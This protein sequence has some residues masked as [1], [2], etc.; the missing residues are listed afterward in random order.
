MYAISGHYG[1]GKTVLASEAV[2]MILSKLK[3]TSKDVDVHVLTFGGGGSSSDMKYELLMKD[4]KN[5]CFLDQAVNVQHFA[6]FLKKFTE[7]HKNHLT[8]KQLKDLK[9]PQEA[10]YYSGGDHFKGVLITICEMMKKFN[11]TCIIMIDELVLNLACRKTTENGKTSY[12]VDFSYLAQYDNRVCQ[13]CQNLEI[14]RYPVKF[15]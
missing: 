2:K 12:H 4:L 11:K 10:K 7:E 15:P 14:A 6:D 3:K 5:K 1:T 8:P 9:Y 13:M